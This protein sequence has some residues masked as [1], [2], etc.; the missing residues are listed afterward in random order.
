MD[1]KSGINLAVVTKLLQEVEPEGV[2]GEEQ[3]R[4]ATEAATSKEDQCTM[5]FK[6]YQCFEK[7]FLA[8]MK[9]KLDQG[10]WIGVK[11]E[12]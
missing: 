1:E 11:G 7:E 3:V 6:L 8:L 4:C 2:I 9:M 12:M 10:E 5:A